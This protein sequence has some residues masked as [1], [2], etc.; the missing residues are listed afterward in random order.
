MLL[1][2]FFLVFQLLIQLIQRLL[3]ALTHSLIKLFL[4]LKLLWKLS[5]LFWQF[6]A[7]IHGLLITMLSW[8]QLLLQVA[9][10]VLLL[11]FL[12][13]D[14]IS[15]DEQLSILLLFLAQWGFEWLDLDLQLLSMFLVDFIFLSSLLNAIVDWL[16]LL[17][18]IFKLFFEILYFLCHYGWFF[19][20]FSPDL[21]ELLDF[22]RF[23]DKLQRKSINLC[24]QLAI[25]ISL[26]HEQLSEFLLTLFQLLPFNL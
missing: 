8:F 22:F 12:Q 10:C 6:V 23:A 18:P 24:F 17:T 1:R 2:F 26:C 25:I 13:V 16:Q 14:S 5:Q 15:F 11:L 9:N 4:P 7:H 20:S 21:L 3:V 19:W